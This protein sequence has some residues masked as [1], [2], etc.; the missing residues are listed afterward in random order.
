MTLPSEPVQ[1][2]VGQLRAELVGIPDD[3]PLAVDVCLNTSGSSRR[4][5]PVIGAGFGMNLDPA[6][7]IFEGQEYPITAGHRGFEDE[8]ATEQARQ[9]P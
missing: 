3:T 1:W 2:T 8:P 7:P 5:L 6:D 9:R 4:R